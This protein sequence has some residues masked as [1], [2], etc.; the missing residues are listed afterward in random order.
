MTDDILQRVQHKIDNGER[1]TFDEGLYLDEHADL[2]LLGRLANQIR[3][4]KKRQLRL[5]Q[6]QRP[7][8][9]DKRLRLPLSILRV[10]SR[11]QGRES[12]CLQ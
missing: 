4:R 5:L 1:I 11:P 6:H 9:S 2:M 8:E 3:E 7:F 12:V 10:S